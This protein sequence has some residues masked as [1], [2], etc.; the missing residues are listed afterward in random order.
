MIAEEHMSTMV[1]YWRILALSSLLVVLISPF[2]LADYQDV[3]PCDKVAAHPQDKQRWGEGVDDKSVAPALAIS[4]C[5]TAVKE[6]P[7][8]PRF[9]F[10]LGRALWT[11]QR[12]KEAVSHFSQAG[13]MNY[14][15]A[16]AYLGDAYRDGVGGVR[17]DQARSMKFYQAAADGGFEHAQGM[18]SA[19]LGEAKKNT[20][21]TEGFLEPEIIQGLYTGDFSLFPT[22]YEKWFINVYL[23]AFSNT[24]S[25]EVKFADIR[26]EN[27]SACGLLYD[28]EIK[29]IA[30]N[31]TMSDHPSLKGSSDPTQQGAK[32]MG[33]M[34]KALLQ[35]REPG[36]MQNLMNYNKL[37]GGM[38]LQTLKAKAERDALNVISRY[39]CDSPVAKQVY[40]NIK[41]YFLGKVSRAPITNPQLTES[42]TRGCYDFARQGGGGEADRQQKCTCATNA[43]LKSG[44]PED[45]QELLSASFTQKRLSRLQNKYP[46]LSENM[47][48]CSMRF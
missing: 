11:A 22:E 1:S 29:Q 10:Q 25:G 23:N 6:H 33:D 14:V 12:Y 24:F 16:F 40:G 2:S 3:H 5:T 39:G 32:L 18:L 31:R 41:P 47:S 36:G 27:Q 34:F 17:A 15:A 19:A 8:T 7:D 45:E 46:R 42:L 26:S 4:R 44:I 35:A 28:P 37:D 21:T 43:I 20:F 13:E 48:S 9:H 30:V 38:A